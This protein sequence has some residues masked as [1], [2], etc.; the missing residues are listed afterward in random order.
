MNTAWSVGLA[1]F[2]CVE[3]A[4][5]AGFFDES[6]GALDFFCC[7]ESGGVAGFFCCCCCCC[8]AAA[9]ALSTQ[10]ARIPQ[11]VRNKLLVFIGSTG[12]AS[13]I[14]WILAHYRRMSA[15]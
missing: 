5:V 9:E 15:M 6:A 11:K 7:V 2:F 14:R 12:D 10:A 4:G 8:C 13:G 1:D 3:S